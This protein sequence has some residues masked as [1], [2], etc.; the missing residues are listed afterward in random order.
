MRT[1]A[2]QEE[3]SELIAKCEAYKDHLEKSK[4]DNERLVEEIRDLQQ[5]CCFLCFYHHQQIRRGIC[6]WIWLSVECARFFCELYFDGKHSFKAH[7]RTN[8][9]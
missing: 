3:A 2:L 9:Q 1:R 8:W 6:H 4:Q 7:F 5:V